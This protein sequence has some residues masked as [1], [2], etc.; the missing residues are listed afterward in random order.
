MKTTIG[1]DGSL[2][3]CKSEGYL[4]VQFEKKEPF[5]RASYYNVFALYPEYIR[6]ESA[7][8]IKK[9]ER[10]VDAYV[11]FNDLEKIYL[12]NKKGLDS[13][14][15]TGTNINFESPTIYDLLS[16]A[17]DINAYCGLD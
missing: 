8:P 9:N 3:T 4:M 16:L 7:I 10:I 17:S 15:D 13:F 2:D 11:S 6:K 12:D 5:D 1:T 14:A